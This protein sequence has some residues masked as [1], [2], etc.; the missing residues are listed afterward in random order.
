MDKT[1]LRLIHIHSCKG[2]GWKTIAKFINFD[3]SLQEIYTLK[4]PHF[5]SLF[6]MSDYNIENFYKDLHLTRPE[7]VY[8][9]LKKARI[10]PLTILDNEYPVYLKQIY[11]PPWVLY[12]KGRISLLQ[13]KCISVVGTRKPSPYGYAVMRKLLPTLI[14]NQWTIVSGLALGIDTEA[15]KIAISE[16]GN[17]I[18][19]LGSGFN[20]IYP[21]I[22]CKLAEKIASEQLLITEFPPDKKAEKWHF[23]FRNRIISGLSKGTLIIEAKERSGSLIT[24]EQ[25]LEQGREVFAVPGS[26]LE[27][28]NQGT[29][30]LIQNGAKLV[31]DAEDILEEL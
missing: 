1:K 3:P 19:I 14:N 2:V 10:H 7:E 4:K 28:T 15:H 20:Y 30:R 24:A 31:I 18:A 5:S 17:T 21:S 9:S 16:N 23:P 29:N 27:A 12:L 26:I 11:D 25:A 8:A 6:Q 13:S 22:N